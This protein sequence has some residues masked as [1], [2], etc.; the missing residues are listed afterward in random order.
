MIKYVTHLLVTKSLKLVDT[1]PFCMIEFK[2]I[3]DTTKNVAVLADV[4]SF[5]SFPFCCLGF[6]DVIANTAVPSCVIIFSVGES[7]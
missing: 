4:T 2:T 5:L 3:W 6:Y 7:T 1:F